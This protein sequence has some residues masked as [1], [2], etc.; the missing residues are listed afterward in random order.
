MSAVEWVW[1]AELGDDAGWDAF[2]DASPDGWWFHRTSWLTY[3]LAYSPGAQDKSFAMVDRSGAI[4]GLV[5]CIVDRKGHAVNGGQP[6][7]APLG[8]CPPIAHGTVSRPGQVREGEVEREWETYVLDLRSP[9]GQRWG[10]VR[11]S[12]RHLITQAREQHDITVIGG[13]QSTDPRWAVERAHAIHRAVAGKETRPQATWDAMGDW[14]QSGNALIAMTEEGY[15]Y[16]IRYKH[17]AY[18]A[19]GATTVTNLSHALLWALETVMWVDGQTQ[20]FEVGWAAKDGDDAKARSI[21][22]FKSGF[23]GDRWPV[24]MV[25]TT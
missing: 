4:Q 16:A 8:I 19:S 1:R 18:Y 17:W 15:A 10:R 12:Y 14:L 24:Q 20:Y 2:V 5:A 22:F 21:A 25:K 11:K 7:V 6:P 9:A 13:G 23:G 3:A